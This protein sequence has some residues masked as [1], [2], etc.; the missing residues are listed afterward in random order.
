MKTKRDSLFNWPACGQTKLRAVLAIAI[1]LS[2]ADPARAGVAD[3][4]RESIE[5]LDPPDDTVATGSWE[6]DTH[7]RLVEEQR[8]VTLAAPLNV[9]MSA[10]GTYDLANPALPGVIPA[11]TVVNSYLLHLDREDPAVGPR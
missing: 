7:I 3:Y 8:G 2:G 5:L 10:A 11:G 1:A 4:S 9:D 6:S